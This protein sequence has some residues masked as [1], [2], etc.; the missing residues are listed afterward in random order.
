MTGVRL[1]LDEHINRVSERVLA[2]SGYYVDQ[3]KDRFGERTVDP[4]LLEWGDQRGLVRRRTLF[5]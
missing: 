5:R 1:L 4:D 3:A 2:E